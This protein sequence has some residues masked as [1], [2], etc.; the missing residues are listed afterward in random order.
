MSRVTSEE[1]KAKR[2]AQRERMAAAADARRARRAKGGVQEGSKPRGGGPHGPAGH[3]RPGEKAQDFKGS[4]SKLVRYLGAY[5]FAIAGV[6]VLAVGSTVFNVVGPKVLGEATTE[7]SNGLV[8]KIAGTGDIDFSAIATILTTVLIL[9]VVASVLQFAQGWIMTTITQRLCFKLRN[10]IAAKINRMPLAHFESH[11]IGDTLSRITNDVDTLGQSLNQSVTTLITSVATVIGIIVLMLTISPL[12]TLI[13]VLVIPVSAVLIMLVVKRSQKYFFA[14]QEYLGRVNGQVEEDYA[15][16]T[17]IKAFNREGEMRRR[18]DEDNDMLY[19]SAWRS[20]FLSGLMMPLMNMV[21]NAGYV[22]VAIAG[23]ALAIQGII[24]IGDIQASIQYVKN[25]SQPITQLAQVSNMFQSMAAAAERVF[26]F[27]EEPEEVPD[28]R[29]ALPAPAEVD[30]IEFDHVRFG[31]KPDKPVIRDFS[32]QVKRG[33]T[34]ALVGPTGAGKSTMVKLLMRFYDVDGGA[35]RMNGADIRDYRRGDLRL[36]FAMVLQDTW[37]FKGSIREN[38]RYGRLDA[39]DEEVRRAAEAADADHFISRLPNGYDT[40]INEDATNISQGQRQLLTIARAILS[41]AEVLIL[42]EA[43]SSVD[44][45]TEELIQR[46]MDT[47]MQGR[48]SF[49]IAHRLSTIRNA[50]LILVI[51]H[52]DIVEQGTHDE[53]LAQGGF[54]ADLYGSQFEDVG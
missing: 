47:L 15:G 3:M 33:Q 37:L 54:Y 17:V 26:R 24:T 10:D 9:Y 51:D 1:R 41:D 18:F 38:I 48:T 45:R 43:T 8:A 52:G 27:L 2:A 44:T 32:A 28:A 29:H 19:E 16:Q 12:I 6:M 36:Q 35:I 25:L 30:S 4:V 39:T 5:K 23:S 53:L 49:V 22:A 46:A 14:Q 31:Y 34:V 21:A 50:D 40:E 20:Q 42:D 7:L 13:S 11:P